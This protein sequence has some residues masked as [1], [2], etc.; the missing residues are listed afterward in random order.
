M[1]RTKWL[2][3]RNREWNVFDKAVKSSFA[4]V[5]DFLEAKCFSQEKHLQKWNFHFTK[6]SMK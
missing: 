3:G 5:D 2:R 6:S 4:T 1:E